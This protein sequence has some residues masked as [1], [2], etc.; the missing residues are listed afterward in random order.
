P[1]RRDDAV[2][3]LVVDQQRYAAQDDQRQAA[4]A[5]PARQHRGGVLRQRR[6]RLA[7]RLPAQRLR[8][9]VAL[10]GNR[11]RHYSD[12][13]SLAAAL[14]AARLSAAP[15]A[16]AKRNNYGSRYPTMPQATP[17]PWLMTSMKCCSR[18][19]PRCSNSRMVQPLRASRCAMASR[20][21]LWPRVTT[22]TVT[23]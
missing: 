14:G 19:R 6:R 12:T 10:L 18:L 13:P 22:S 21:S 5:D 17:S 20:K 1:G 16:A 15:R 3:A 4:R 8:R 9:V 2:V 7:R 23:T 11:L